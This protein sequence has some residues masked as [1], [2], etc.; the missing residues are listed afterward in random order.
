MSN[1]YFLTQEQVDWLDAER[2]RMQRHNCWLLIG[3][4]TGYPCLCSDCDTP[5]HDAPVINLFGSP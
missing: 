2:L 5:G 4:F 1:N 3:R